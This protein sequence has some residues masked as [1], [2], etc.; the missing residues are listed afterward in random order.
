VA[1]DHS[2][3]AQQLQPKVLAEA[4]GEARALRPAKGFAPTSFAA[5]Q[6]KNGC[7]C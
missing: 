1:A 6:W 2:V 3:A 7:R 5:R 4:I